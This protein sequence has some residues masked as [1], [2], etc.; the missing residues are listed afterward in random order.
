M[1]DEQ[2]VIELL[3]QGRA[4][5]G[6]KLKRSQE[7]LKASCM[8]CHKSIPIGQDYIGLMDHPNFAVC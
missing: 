8:L 7:W 3:R 4:G 5:P 2:Q 1:P 6:I